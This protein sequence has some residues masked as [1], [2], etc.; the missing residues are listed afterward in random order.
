MPP[1]PGPGSDRPGAAHMLPMTET[2]HAGA[3]PA[4]DLIA[5]EA[6]ARAAAAA[7]A[8]IRAGSGMIAIPLLATAWILGALFAWALVHGAA[9]LRRREDRLPAAASPAEHPAP[10]A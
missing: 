8:A 5:L 3:S 7:A 6:T 2:T 9:K 4:L 10:V 1:G